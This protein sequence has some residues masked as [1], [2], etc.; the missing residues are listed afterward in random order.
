LLLLAILGPI[1]S[2][3]APSFSHDLQASTLRV[4]SILCTQFAIPTWHC[5][6]FHWTQSFSTWTHRVHLG[7]SLPVLFRL[8]EGGWY[9]FF[10]WFKTFYAGIL[11]VIILS[12]FRIQAHVRQYQPRH[13]VRY[14][15]PYRFVLSLEIGGL[16]LF[17]SRHLS[18]IRHHQYGIRMRLRYRLRHE[19]KFKRNESNT[20]SNTE[21]K[22]LRERSA[23]SPGNA[24]N[25]INL[26]EPGRQIKNPSSPSSDTPSDPETPP[27]HL[28]PPKCEPLG[29]F[30][31]E[32]VT[33]RPMSR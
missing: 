11:L 15:I 12:S 5:L 26:D 24:N 2:H 30:I 27:E 10:R 25:N 32:A 8:I 14:W 23:T 9:T 28:E 4:L 1:W 16:A 22:S 21:H 31:F 29:L 33:H 3:L 19:V 20:E 18:P 6:L 17:N 7:L 13:D